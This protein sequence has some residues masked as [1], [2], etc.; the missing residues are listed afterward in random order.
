MRC[1]RSAGC[2]A[3][4]F[5]LLNVTQQEYSISSYMKLAGHAGRSILRWNIAFL[6]LLA[7]GF[8]TKT[9]AASR[10]AARR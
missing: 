10:R 1:S 3:A 2:V 5:F 9:T 4:L 7:I 8:I 6:C